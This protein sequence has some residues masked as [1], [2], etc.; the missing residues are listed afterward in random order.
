LKAHDLMPVEKYCIV[1]VHHRTI[2][3]ANTMTQTD[4]VFTW[5]T[6]AYCLTRVDC[7]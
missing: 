5:I 4:Q 6:E 7:I 1:K 3:A 2:M